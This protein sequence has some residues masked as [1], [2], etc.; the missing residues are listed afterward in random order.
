[1]TNFNQIKNVS[2]SQTIQS[3]GTSSFEEGNKD[4]IH[5]IYL[6]LNDDSSLR[7]MKIKSRQ[8]IP[9]KISQITDFIQHLIKPKAESLT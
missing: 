1:M 3:A 7:L 5:R 9:D 8:E 6:L 2:V 4:Y